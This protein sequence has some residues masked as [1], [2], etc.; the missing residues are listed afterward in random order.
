MNVTAHQEKEKNEETG[1]GKKKAEE[2]KQGTDFK[3]AMCC[4]SAGVQG[5]AQQKS[6]WGVPG[7]TGTLGR[8]SSH[9]DLTQTG[10]GTVRSR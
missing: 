1:T 8:A 6:E 9:F 10:S 4:P 2:R 3:E 5:T 7:V